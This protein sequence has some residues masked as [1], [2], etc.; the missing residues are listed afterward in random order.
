M[1]W[2]GALSVVSL[3]HGLLVFSVLSETLPRMLFYDFMSD[4]A[5][6]HYS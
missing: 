6:I 1:P 2:S 3:L 4:S 5:R